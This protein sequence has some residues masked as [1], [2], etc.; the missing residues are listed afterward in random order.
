MRNSLIAL[1]AFA[2]LAACDQAPKV[3]EA[4]S[5]AKLV[6]VSLEGSA[7]NDDAARIAHGERISWALGCHGCHGNELH[8]KRFDE[9]YASNLTREVPKYSDAQL[10]RLIRSGIHPTGREVWAMPSEVFQHLSD[11]DLEAI[12][13]Y[14]RTLEPAGEPTGKP[15]PFEPDAQKL[16]AEGKIMP[17]AQTVLQTKAKTPPDLGETH[18]LGRYVTMVTCAEC[19]GPELKGQEGDTPDLIVAGGYSRDEFETLMTK[20]IPSGGRKFKN[21]LMGEVA[22]SRFGHFTPHERYALYAYLKARAERSQ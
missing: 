5:A 19:H 13:A 17:A 7:S 16:I 3:E 8:G 22:R 1:A 2:A 14:L 15:L 10:D 21:P 18:A 12:I 9:L 4:A 20:G 11:A 6:Q